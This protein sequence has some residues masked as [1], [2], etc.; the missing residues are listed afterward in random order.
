[1]VRLNDW[2]PHSDIDWGNISVAET[3]F[4]RVEVSYGYQFVCIGGGSN[5]HKSNIGVKGLLLEENFKGLNFIPAVS[6]GMIWKHSDVSLNPDIH[7]SAWDFYLVATK[8]ITQLP[9]P[10]LL[11]A[12]VLS[13]QG[14]VTG[15]LGFDRS[16][17]YGKAFANIDIIPFSNIVIENIKLGS[18]AV[19]FEW[20]GGARYND[21]KD[22]D[23]M[24]VHV[25]WFANKSLSVAV[26]YTYTGN[27]KS[28]F[29]GGKFGLG[30]GFVL[31]GQYAF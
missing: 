6:A 19:G 17:D 9:W 14:R 30:S 28:K 11:S 20:K 18:I 2:A 7:S 29:N 24:D 25:A 27:E 1:Y 8:M 15:V 3:F 21:W 31:S 5:V 12:G 10:V 22:K 4:K 16:R 13:T 23:Y 26:A